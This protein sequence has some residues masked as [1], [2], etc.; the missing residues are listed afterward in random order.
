MQGVLDKISNEAK[1]KSRLDFIK[2]I[3]QFLNKLDY[4][5]KKIKFIL[6]LFLIQISIKFKDN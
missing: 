4:F 3:H 1:E 2:F 6:K 5:Q